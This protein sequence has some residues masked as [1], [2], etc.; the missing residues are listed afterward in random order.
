MLLRLLKKFISTVLV[1]QP[2]VPM[3]IRPPNR[4]S[5]WML[6][7]KISMKGDLVFKYSKKKSSS[8]LL[9]ALRASW[10]K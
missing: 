5:I 2:N 6:R 3:R 1:F 4:R 10:A 8:L 9:L 7:E